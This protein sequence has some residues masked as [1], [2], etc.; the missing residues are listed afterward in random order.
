MRCTMSFI[1]TSFTGLVSTLL[2][3]TMTV[4]RSQT[5]KI[6]PRLWEM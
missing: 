1:V 5:S 4:T 3:S 6:S 2:P